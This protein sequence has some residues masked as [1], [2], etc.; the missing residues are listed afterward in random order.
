MTTAAVVL[1]AGRASRFEAGDGAKLLAP[2]RGRPLV[3]WAVDAAVEAGFDEVLVITGAADLTA[4]LPPGV[5]VVDN[6]RWAEGQATSLAAA[7][8]AAAERGHDAVVVGLGD[9]PLVTAGAWRAVGASP[10]DIAVATYDGTRRNPV[11]LARPVWPELDREGD[12]GAR[13]L[14]RRRPELVAEVACA[15]D[16]VDVDTREDLERWS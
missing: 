12:E 11:R 16:P 15:G 10:A 6:A 8:D 3:R 13:T 1:A 2:F 5:V 7:V 14:M 9:Q 4:V